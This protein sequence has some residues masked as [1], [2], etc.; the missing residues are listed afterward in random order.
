M[1]DDDLKKDSWKHLLNSSCMWGMC[2][3]CLVHQSYQAERVWVVLHVEHSTYRQ[4]SSNVKYII[5]MKGD[6]ILGEK[7]SLAT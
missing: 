2:K 6:S 3:T 5:I 1:C 4:R 7:L